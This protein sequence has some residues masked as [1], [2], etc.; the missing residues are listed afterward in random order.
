MENDRRVTQPVANGA[1]TLTR[2]GLLQGAGWL[3]AAAAFPASAWP[4]IQPVSSVMTK[5]STYMSEAQTRALPADVIEKTKQHTLDTMA[6]IVS[7]SQLPPGRFAIKFAHEH[8]G[9]T[10]STV[11][12]SNV[13]CDPIQAAFA[14][15]MLAHSDETDDSHA[16]SQ[17]HPGSSIV[18]AALAVGEQF[19]ADGTRFLS[20]VAL[21]YDIGTRVTM[22]IGF[23]NFQTVTHLSTHSVAGIFGSAAAAASIAKLNVQQMRWV[24]DYASQQTAGI[25]AWQRDTEHIQKAFVFAGQPA[26]NGVTAALLVQSGATG[27]D[28][29]LSGADSFLEVYGPKA[30]PAILTEKLGERYEVTRTN[31]KKWT[32]GSP[33]QAPLDA[34]VLLQKKHPFDADQVQQVV[35]RVAPSEGA[36]VNNREMPDI[37]MQHLIAVMLID[38]TVSFRTAHDK[39]RMQDPAVLRQRAKVHLVLD[40]QL[41]RELPKR[42]A[43]V[44]VTIADG[45]KLSE[46]VDAVRG[47]EENP[48]TRDE[49]VSKSRELMNPVLG[50]STSAKLI[51]KLLDLENV[52]DIRELRPLLRRT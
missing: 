1:G 7:G 36:V 25:M 27:I 44:E 29:I 51:E 47:T 32:V 11:V 37:C 41:E 33:I 19:G 6:A 21:G 50:E 43:I 31:I 12:A 18:P 40:D 2:R 13:L 52:K 30:D 20:A 26:R 46:R 15:A 28:D 5:L 42:V 35:V 45:T 8:A 16:P 14:N 17:S 49:V 38:K 3:V 48:M 34:L 9:E 4:D 10:V 22:T 24:L 39:P 23:P